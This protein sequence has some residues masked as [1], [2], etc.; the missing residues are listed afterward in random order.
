MT[1][2][3]TR[4][5]LTTGKHSIASAYHA[6][7]ARTNPTRQLR[8][9]VVPFSFGRP[10]DGVLDD[11]TKI[12]H[13]VY[14]PT[15]Y[16]HLPVVPSKSLASLS[17]ALDKRC[18]YFTS[19]RVHKSIRLANADL[20]DEICPE[21]LEPI[22]WSIELFNKWNAQFDT[23]KQAR[24]A[25][26]VR[27]GSVA[28][29][30]SRDFS[31]KQIFVK[32]EALLKRHDKDWAPRII[33]QSSDIHNSVLGPIMQEC[34]KRMFKCFDQ[35]RGPDTVE[36]MGAYKKTSEEIVAHLQRAGDSRSLFI[37]TDFTANDSSQV[38]DVHMLE[39]AWLR[40]LGAPMWLTSLMLIANNYVA[41]NYTY[42]MKVRIKN[43]L[44]TGSQSTTFRN[45][46]WNATIMKAFCV[47][48]G[49][50]GTACILGDDNVLRLDN[51]TKR[52]QFYIRQ[53]EFIAK[54]AHMKVKVST[55]KTLQGV[56]FL[57]RWF[58]QLANGTYVM[59]PF[60][61][62]AIA[63]FNVCPNPKQDPASYI[64]GKALSYSYE[65]RNFP[66]IKKLFL[67]KF[68]SLYEEGM[69][70][71]S[72][73]SWNLRGLFIRLGLEG[74][75]QEI[76]RPGSVGFLYDFTPLVHSKFGIT[77]SDYYHAV[78]AILFKDE[79]ISMDSLGFL[80]DEWL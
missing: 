35:K 58:T 8:F 61:G 7:R 68:A 66:A 37:S 15:I 54:L 19:E 39:V 3:L 21:P 53:Y 29:M 52:R 13:D 70:D 12:I 79:D 69:L 25:K 28:E 16:E 48:V 55:S 47:H 45:S 32:M 18:N 5:T 43:Q 65:F 50:V 17:A 51:A 10:K 49:R 57:S 74:I 44:P 9:P 76:K 20:L 77:A 38:L 4:H 26:A 31:D 24:Q 80:D 60:L 71:L 27:Y 62:K 33:Y 1:H 30:T 67:A 6:R 22:E 72:G 56:P 34:T 46:M 64:C 78:F 36:V 75:L 2:T 59:V 63:R 42:A 23:A 40:R 41:T 14:G 11:T 73:V